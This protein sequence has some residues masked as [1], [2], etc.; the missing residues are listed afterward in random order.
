MNYYNEI[1]IELMNNEINRKVKNYSINRSDLGTYYNVGKML[2]EAGKHY[3]ENV[4]GDY[5]SKLKIELN[6]K[7]NERTLRRYRQFYNFV[8]N[9]KWS[10]M[11]TK[12]SWSHITELMVLSDEEEIN[13]Y[14]S[15]VN[16]RNIS[17]RKLSE[18]IKDNEYSRIDEITKNK[19]KHKKSLNIKDFIKSPIVIRN[20][21]NYETISEKVLQKL[22]LEDIES[23]MKE[24]GNSFCF[25]GSEYKI[26]IGNNFNYIDLLL[27]NYEYN[28][29][30]VVELKTTELKKEHVGQIQVYMNYIDENLRKINQ[31]KTIG[32]IICKQDNKYI[33]KYCSDDRIIARE[34]ELV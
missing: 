11:P 16:D 8:T 25:I 3:G 23:F 5:A 13:Y 22:I 9:L 15:L 14:V 31:D 12:L 19:L 29:F 18:L 26:R 6:K 34:Y 17:Y 2:S 7:Y 27:F 24:L 10:A 21:N 32:I 1:K 33:I 28:C 30:V 4:I 20:N